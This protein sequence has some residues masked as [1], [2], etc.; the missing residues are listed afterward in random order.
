MVLPSTCRFLHTV[1]TQCESCDDNNSQK[2][3]HGYRD[4]N[5]R[6]TQ[7]TH[8]HTHTYRGNSQM[9]HASFNTIVISVIKCMRYRQRLHLNVMHWYLPAVFHR[10][11][12]N[13][14]LFPLVCVY[15]NVCLCVVLVNTANIEVIH[16]ITASNQSCWTCSPVNRKLGVWHQIR[17]NNV[18]CTKIPVNCKR[19]ILMEFLLCCQL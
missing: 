11:C 15:M 13:V 18:K 1:L 2:V 5:L 12:L 10:S 17:P 8:T 9:T 3:L 14:R 4:D 6:H 19:P 16:L 7:G